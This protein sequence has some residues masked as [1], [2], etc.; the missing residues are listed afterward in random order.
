[1]PV[2]FKQRANTTHIVVHCS[3]TRPSQDIGAAE[4]DKWHK[5]KRWFAIGYHMVIRRNGKVETGRPIDAIGAHAE[6][7]NSVSVGVVL[8]GGVSETNV[9]KAESNFTDEQFES[10][11]R[12]LRKL[13]GLYP[14]VE[15]LGHRDLPKVKKD[16]P[17][18]DV[19][20]WL[21]TISL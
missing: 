19:R 11:I 8:I 2:S 16:C 18:F 14:D 1:M 7:F 15:I 20:E 17:S 3:A 9:N 13:K 12:V 10:L 6:N 21:S 5:Q 4:I